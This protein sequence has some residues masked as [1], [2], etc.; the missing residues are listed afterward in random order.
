MAVTR[1]APLTSDRRATVLWVGR[2]IPEDLRIV[3]SVLGLKLANP[4][5]NKIDSTAPD[6]HSVLVSMD[7]LGDL[8]AQGRLMHLLSKNPLDYGVMLGIVSADFDG[9]ARL[10]TRV[11][12]SAAAIGLEPESIRVVRPTVEDLSQLLRS[13]DPGPAADESIQIKQKR[14]AS[15]IARTDEILLRRAFHGFTHLELFEETG[16][17][18]EACCVWRVDA[19]HG[20][21]SREPF[22]AKAAKRRALETERDTYNEFVLDRIPFPFRAPLIESRFVKGMSRALLVSMFVDRAQRLDRYLATATS[23]ELVITSL[24]TS[25]LQNWRGS[26]RLVRDKTIGAIY[27]DRQ[28]TPE[29]PAQAAHAGTRLLPNPLTL[30]AAFERAKGR[31]K[32]LL[33]PTE[34]WR[35][36]GTAG[37][38]DFHVAPVHGDLNVRNVF[39]RWNSVDAVL[40]DFSHSGQE[41]PL[42]RDPAKLDVSIALTAR[43]GKNHFMPNTALSELYRHPLLPPRNFKVVDGRTAAIRQIRRQAG[44]EGITPVEYEILVACHLLRYASAPKD[45]G[46]DREKQ[47][48]IAYALASDLIVRHAQT[49][50]GI[51]GR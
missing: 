33:A 41:D 13:H 51:A 5:I 37:R 44:G 21:H 50:D 45:G 17:R 38:I 30:G 49:T 39:V 9:A 43:D 2:Q 31:H 26:M 22:V 29:T 28:K 16:G 19:Y 7:D 11:L 48:A 3:A 32:K 24:F 10:Q 27:V 18:S 47:R 25:A 46:D 1:E 36:L 15:S 34:L 14:G 42:A 12:E 20:P 4:R 40:I 8:K 6:L 35:L 23:P